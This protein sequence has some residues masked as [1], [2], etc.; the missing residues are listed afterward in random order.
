M[1]R[2]TNRESEAQVCNVIHLVQDD[3]GWKLFNPLRLRFA[4]R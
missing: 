4:I 2:R 3:V 1:I